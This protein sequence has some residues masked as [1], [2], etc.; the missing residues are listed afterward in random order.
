MVILIREKRTL[1]DGKSI[2]ELAYRGS[3]KPTSD[4]IKRAEELDIFLAHRMIAISKELEGKGLL[5]KKQ[6]NIERWYWTGKHI[7]LFV[8]DPKIVAPEIKQQDYYIW[9]AIEQNTP[10]KLQPNQESKM[11]HNTF[12]KRNH[13]RLC[14][15]VAKFSEET[16]MSHTWREWVE[17]LESP[18][19]L[20]D[21]R[22][23]D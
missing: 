22:I 19:L 16:V 6:G 21:N 1:E 3:G 10:T 15:L 12:T 23:F 14:Y 17:I 7:S 4:E 9:I 2:I 11:R 5:D 8:D 18:S 20:E 13:Y